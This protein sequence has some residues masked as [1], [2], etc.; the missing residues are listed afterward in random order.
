MPIDVNAT[1]MKCLVSTDGRNRVNVEPTIVEGAME[2]PTKEIEYN[3]HKVSAT[4]NTG[5]R[6]ET[7]QWMNLSVGDAY[8]SVYDPVAGSLYRAGKG[9][10]DLQCWFE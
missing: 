4:F 1:P 3:G 7:Q 10:T 2:V 9:N 6:F 5:D 8:G